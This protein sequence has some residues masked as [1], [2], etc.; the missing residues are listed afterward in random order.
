MDRTSKGLLG[1]I[2]A[3]LFANALTSA[4]PVA[5]AAETTTCRIEGPVEVRLTRI[6]DDLE[7]KWGFSQPGS[8]SSTPLHVK[9]AD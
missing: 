7:L 3:G 9:A 5:W 2:A 8:S 1:L 6:D 4:V